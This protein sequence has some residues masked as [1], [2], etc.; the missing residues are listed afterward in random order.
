MPE[1]L[2]IVL[3]ILLTP[4]WGTLLMLM[5]LMI[6]TIGQVAR[7]SAL[8]ICTTTKRLRMLAPQLRCGRR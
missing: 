6:W 4:P 7:L 3:T 1:W 2:V 5:A 8:A